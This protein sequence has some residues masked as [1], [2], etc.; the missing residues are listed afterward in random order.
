MLVGTSSNPKS[1]SSARLPRSLLPLRSPSS[2]KF[3]SSRSS[4]NSSLCRPVRPLL[5]P[6]GAKLISSSSSNKLSL[7][8]QLRA[9]S[10]GLGVVS[11]VFMA[12]Q[13][14]GVFLP[15][16]TCT[17]IPC[18]YCVSLL[19]HDSMLSVVVHDPMSSYHFRLASPSIDLTNVFILTNEDATWTYSSPPFLASC[20]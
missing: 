14:L 3:S 18:P 13:L 6:E 12:C 15:S 5:D 7:L 17:L 9:M 20:L 19:Y 16:F 1:L 11:S 2:N 8:R 4:S 10:I